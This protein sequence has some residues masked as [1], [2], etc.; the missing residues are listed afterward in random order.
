[1]K[2]AVAVPDDVFELADRLAHRMRVSRSR[3]YSLALSEY[4]ARHDPDAVTEAVDRVCG[5]LDSTPDVFVDRAARDRLEA[6]EW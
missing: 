5:S 1:M 4:L 2:V 3:L 6:E